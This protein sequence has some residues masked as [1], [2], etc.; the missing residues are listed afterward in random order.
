MNPAVLQKQRQPFSCLLK[1]HEC[2]ASTVLESAVYISGIPC[3]RA[4][5]VIKI[6]CDEDGMP[7]CCRIDVKQCVQ[8]AA[9]EEGR[10]IYNNMKAFIRYMI[11]SN[12][13][14]VASIFLT[15]ATGLPEGLIP[16]QVGMQ[17]FSYICWV[18]KFRGCCKCA[19]QIGSAC[20]EQR[21]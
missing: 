21:L 14:E 3:M 13:G 17:D 4:A 2:H 11:S 7:W 6:T 19:P 10:A 1:Q 9:V 18:M 12:I 5:S 16:V 15:A 20:V 8:V